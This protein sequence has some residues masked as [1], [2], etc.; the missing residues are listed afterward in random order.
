MSLATSVVSIAVVLCLAFIF[1][2]LAFN[3]K[4]VLKVAS[5]AIAMVLWFTLAIMYPTFDS[6]YYFVGWAF[7]MPGVFTL[8]L[9][10][11]SIYD[12]YKHATMEDWQKDEGW[13]EE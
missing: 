2:L 12:T 5:Y 13:E 3:W 10:A 4:K 7:M 8:L 6:T 1:T 11:N 9:T